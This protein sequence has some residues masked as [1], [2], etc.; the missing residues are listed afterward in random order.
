MLTRGNSVSDALTWGN[1][2]AEYGELGGGLKYGGLL[3]G[4]TQGGSAMTAGHLSGVG[5]TG[6]GAITTAGGL[7][8]AF[9]GGQI[10]GDTVSNW[11]E[12]SKYGGDKTLDNTVGV[13]TGVGALAGG[14][15]AAAAGLGLAS[16]PIGWIGLA[17]GGLALAG[18]AAYDYS[19]RLKHGAEQ[20]DILG[21]EFDTLRDQAKQ[22]FEA[23]EKEIKQLENSFYA[24]S[25]ETERRQLLVNNGII[26]EENNLSLTN[27]EME[28]YIQNLTDANINMN[29][30]SE[31]ILNGFESEYSQK[32]K[33]EISAAIDNIYGSMKGKS[34]E[35]QREMLKYLGADEQMIDAL[36]KN[37]VNGA[38]SDGELWRAFVDKEG[39]LHGEEFTS[40]TEAI[41]S[42]QI[43]TSRIN[44]YINKYGDEME[45]KPYVTSESKYMAGVDMLASTIGYLN[46]YKEYGSGK[47]EP[48]DSKASGFDKNTYDDYKQQI[49]SLNDKE[50]VEIAFKYTGIPSNDIQKILSD[51]PNS[52]KGYK[53]GSTYIPNDMIAQLHEGERVLTANQNKEYTE[54]LTTGRTDIIQIGLQDVVSAIRQQT[55]DIL[56]Y[57][58]ELS[59]SS[60]SSMSSMLNMSP[61][62]GNTRVTY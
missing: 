23:K 36:M 40:I 6:L 60:N 59:I 46:Q 37:K 44:S 28:K 49:L 57:L 20:V 8:M 19:E 14:G 22:Q 9:K 48:T 43:S 18:K 3:G 24:L 38:A 1:A 15:M 11:N 13:A 42:G 26:P 21:K 5:A 54:E 56:T 41:E 2:A 25:D 61:V 33:D 10:L 7:M 17:V 30:V 62:M 34:E 12:P 58:R 45:Y 39:K 51:Y 31:D 50:K 35:E 32:S 16:G 29:S 52:L 47:K 55:N 27:E 53:L 4:F